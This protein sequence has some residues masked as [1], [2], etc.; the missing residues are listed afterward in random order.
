M[1]SKSSIAWKVAGVAALVASAAVV[2]GAGVASAGQSSTV[3]GVVTCD[4]ELGEQV[5]DWT[6]ANNTTSFMDI[7]G[8]TI[9]ATALTA[10]SSLDTSVTMSPLLNILSLGT[11]VGTSSASGDAVGVLGLTVS[12]YFNQND[13]FGTVTGTVTLAPCEAAPTTTVAP[14]TAAP[15]TVAPETTAL[16][17]G[18]GS[19]PASGNDSTLP[20]L[21]GLMV[22]TGGGLLLLR[23]RTVTN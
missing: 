2:G 3:T 6:L 10:G 13:S 23:R 8:A 20:I 5:I 19:L 18:G 22:A 7:S 14:T 12:V 16:A 9:D 4:T 15:T 1:G 17:A 21:A 11:S